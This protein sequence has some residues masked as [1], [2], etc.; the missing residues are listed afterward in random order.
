MEILVGK[1]STF[2]LAKLWRCGSMLKFDIRSGMAIVAYII[3]DVPL[4]FFFFF[5]IG[6]RPSKW[7]TLEVAP[8]K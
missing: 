7:Q 6:E 4:L 5:T 8:V 3:G 1:N 2:H